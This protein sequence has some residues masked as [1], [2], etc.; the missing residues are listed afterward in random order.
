MSYFNN[1]YYNPNNYPQTNYNTMPTNY[2]N[3]N[4]TARYGITYA[5][6]EEV[7]AYILPPNAQMLALDREKS[8]FY[9]KSSDNLGRSMTE[10][11][12][13]EKVTNEPEKVKM[14]ENY[15][16]KDDLS[17]LI[18]RAEFE[19][20]MAQCKDIEKLLKVN[21]SASPRGGQEVPRETG[22]AQ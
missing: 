22:T 18:T 13:Y 21:K 10:I 9:V 17:N 8:V 4:N 7:K 15:V 11:F 1:N 16:T 19:S 5:T 6:E 2:T 20:F 3:L 14:P 12:K